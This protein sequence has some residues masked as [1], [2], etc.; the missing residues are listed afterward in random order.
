MKR[1]HKRNDPDSNTGEE[2][3]KGEKA[4]KMEESG[5][6][7]ESS[8]EECLRNVGEFVANM[9]NTFGKRLRPLFSV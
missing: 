5:E 6:Q 4:E 7:G 9:L 3:E 8:G 2:K 1:W